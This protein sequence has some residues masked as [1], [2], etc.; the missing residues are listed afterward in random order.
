MGL[1]VPMKRSV[2]VEK[3]KETVILIDVSEVVER[4]ET[5][6]A[7]LLIKFSKEISV[8][9][10]M[11]LV[12]TINAHLQLLVACLRCLTLK[13]VSKLQVCSLQMIL[14]KESSSLNIL[15]MSHRLISVLLKKCYTV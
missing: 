8:R 5:S 15:A 3:L 10:W 9:I 4:T 14:K 6:K 12:K 11:S 13:I 1:I 7:S 2:F